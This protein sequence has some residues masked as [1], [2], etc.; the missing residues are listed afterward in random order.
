MSDKNMDDFEQSSDQTESSLD[1]RQSEKF[2]D[3]IQL[4]LRDISREEL[5]LAEQEFYLAIIV[6]AKGQLDLYRCG[7]FG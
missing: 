1:P 2:D 3:T 7:E 6:Q 4:Y 5:L